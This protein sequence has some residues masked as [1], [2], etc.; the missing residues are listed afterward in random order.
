ME[1][2]NIE[3]ALEI[4]AKLAAGET[5]SEQGTNAALYQEY[6]TNP[7]VYDLSLIHI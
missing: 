5:V 4:S 6:S 2:R 1:S 3:K 7:E